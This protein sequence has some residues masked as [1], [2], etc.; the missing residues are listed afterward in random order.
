MKITICRGKTTESV[1]C[2]VTGPC[3]R[4]HHR[5][6]A[7][8]LYWFGRFTICRS[9]LYQLWVKPTFSLHLLTDNHNSRTWCYIV[10][11]ISQFTILNLLTILVMWTN[12]N[13][14]WDLLLK[15]SLI[16]IIKCIIQYNNAITCQNSVT[17]IT[18]SSSKIP[19]R[20]IQA[21]HHCTTV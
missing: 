1:H 18:V 14:I 21:T 16:S 3:L 11:C 4:M 19:L 7:R 15:M 6:S 9:R 17:V 20:D 2:T 10:Y 5:P 12:R 13:K 8:R